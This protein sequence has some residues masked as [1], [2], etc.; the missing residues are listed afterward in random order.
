MPKR[1][2]GQPIRVFVVEFSRTQCELLVSLVRADGMIV[3]G[4]A[5]DGASAIAAV[6]RLRP[7]VIVMNIDL[8][9]IDGYVATRQIMQE[10]PTPIVLISSTWVISKGHE[11]ALAAG[12]SLVARRRGIYFAPSQFETGF[13]STAH[14]PEDLERTG[15]VLNEVFAQL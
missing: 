2:A 3:V 4:T 14:L 8:P 5:S 15:C 6:R 10:C 13:I 11:R 7:E 12:E 9:G 1:A